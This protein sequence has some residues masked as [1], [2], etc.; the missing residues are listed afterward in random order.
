MV[1]KKTGSKSGKKSV[2]KL[3]NKNPVARTAHLF[4]KA[5]VH[6]DKKQSEKRTPKK[7]NL[8]DDAGAMHESPLQDH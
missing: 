2:K 8:L 7:K 4:N 5:A 6:T 1:E 3:T